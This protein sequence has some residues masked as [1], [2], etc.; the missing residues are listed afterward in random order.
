MCASPEAAMSIRT[1]L[2]R[3]WNPVTTF[4]TG[5]VIGFLIGSRTVW[6]DGFET[7]LPLLHPCAVVL[8]GGAER[9]M[10]E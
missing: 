9:L 1:I 6:Y 7:L 3:L 5:I 2:T 10:T 8:L 4:F